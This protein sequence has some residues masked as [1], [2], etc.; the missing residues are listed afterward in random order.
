ML[1]RNDIDLAL[2]QMRQMARVAIGAQESLL[3]S[4]TDPGVFEMPAV[5]ANILSFACFDLLARI[6]A[7]EAA[8][9][10]PCPDRHAA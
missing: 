3:G 8:I 9:C 5:E 6:E 10:A 7:L 4:E 1:D 2:Y